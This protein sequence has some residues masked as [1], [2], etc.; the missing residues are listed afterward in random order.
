MIEEGEKWINGNKVPAIV[1]AFSRIIS[2][3]SQN[4]HDDPGVIGSV[5]KDVHSK[6]S[7]NIEG[8]DDVGGE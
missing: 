7:K 1:V 3:P 4:S 8:S 6:P 2:D 5:S